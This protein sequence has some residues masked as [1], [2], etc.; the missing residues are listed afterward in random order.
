MVGVVFFPIVGFP[1]IAS[2][3]LLHVTENPSIRALTWEN[4]KHILTSRCLTS[5]YPVRTLTLAI[6]YQIWGPTAGGFKLTNGLIHL[7]NTYLVFWLILR[8]LRQWDTGVGSP[9]AWWDVAVAGVAAGLFAVHPVVVEPVAWV[10][11]REELLT[12]LGALGCVHF[13]LSARR[14]S[15]EGGK[16]RRVLVLHLAAIFCCAAACLSNAVAAVIPLLVV[17]CDAVMPERP[18]A[19]KIVRDSLPLWVLGIVTIAIKMG[20]GDDAGLIGE[21]AP[22][23]AGRLML[24]LNVY[25]ANLST[26][27]L[28]G[29]L[30]ISYSPL[31]PES[32]LEGEVVL[33][34]IAI[35][36]TC[37]A[38]WLLR[39]RRVAVFGL[40]W[41]VIALGPSS[42]IMVHHIHLA[43]RFL[44]FPLA[45]A[46]IAA[47]GCLRRLGYLASE[48]HARM[49]MAAAGVAGLVAVFL[50]IRFSAHQVHF[51]RDSIVLWEQTVKAAPDNPVAHRGLAISLARAG[52]I[53]QAFEEFEVALR[54]NPNYIFALGDYAFYLVNRQ[55]LKAI[56]LAKRGCE[57]TGWKDPDLRSTLA[58]AY[59]SR[60]DTLCQEGDFRA[61]LECYAKA[62]ETDPGY[63]RPWTQSA[64]LRATCPDPE[65]R[66]R[67]KAA[68]LA[69][70]ALPMAASPAQLSVLGETYAAIG[71]FD[72]AV[73]AVAKGLRLAQAAG[74][75]ELARELQRQLDRY[76][77]Q[78]SQ[79]KSP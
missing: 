28:P 56:E 76:R 54:L 35:G 48:R 39:R 74:E 12:A 62:I 68:Q 23:S 11:G 57:L 7:A 32:F 21:A 65:L 30:G 46:A 55:D 29:E 67:A 71:Q 13:H 31:R 69:D 22:F 17:A 73:G 19:W 16:P 27:V 36:L 66:D 61:A 60:A 78:S 18:K 9:K 38:L 59:I 43:D 41:F 45:G 64:Y 5:Y 52:Q 34:A 49:G 24:V 72:K 63:E 37:A 1:F 15:R 8:L 6:D 33:G 20:A 53:D 79:Q 70:R 25:W 75:R 51:W 4:V 3:S 26:L 42:Q 44:Y 2:D 58:G 40:L 10:S 47:G 50:L 77:A 14:W